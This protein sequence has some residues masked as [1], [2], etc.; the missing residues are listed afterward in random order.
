MRTKSIIITLLLLVVAC[1]MEA[2]N[3]FKIG[4]C[5]RYGTDV[6][7]TFTV[8]TDIED[9]YPFTPT[10]LRV[11]DESGHQYL[12]SEFTYGEQKT[13]SGS[14]WDTAPYRKEEVYGHKIFNLEEGVPILLSVTI[15]DVPTTLKGFHRIWLR[16]THRPD[17]DPNVRLNDK[18][19]SLLY[20]SEV[21]D[22][23]ITNNH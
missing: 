8:T 11:Y 3:V 9:G 12:T 4:K 21:Y 5:V 19:F 20:K 6:V 10:D 17:R 22:M 16:A 14:E 18:P 2:G 23:T 15:Y 1:G 13:P 7:V